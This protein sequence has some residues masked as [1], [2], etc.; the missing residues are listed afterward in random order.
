MN[1]FDHRS[2]SLT[3]AHRGSR[4][5][6]VAL[7][8][9]FILA[10]PM[11]SPAAAVT[12]A[13]I[14]VTVTGAATNP[15]V[16]DTFSFQVGVQ[17]NGPDAAPDVSTRTYFSA[18]WLDFVSFSSADPAATCAI[19]N[20][21]LQCAFGGLEAGATSSVTIQATRLQAASSY[22]STYSVYTQT[23][24]DPYGGN[25][26]DYF[27]LA[28]DRDQ[29]S[30]LSVA[31]TGS[32]QPTVGSN[33]TFDTTVSNLGPKAA[34]N[35]ALT[36]YL[37]GVQ[38][39]FVSVTSANCTYSSGDGEVDCFFPSIPA[40]DTRTVTVTMQRLTGD[41]ISHNASVHLE[42]N[43]DPDSSNNYEYYDI[44]GSAS[45]GS[46]FGVTLTGPSQTPDVG[47]TSNVVA[48]ATNL[49]PLADIGHFSIDV[50]VGLNALS[51]T[52]TNATCAV[53]NWGV[54]CVSN[55]LA[56]SEKA[57]VTVA[58]KRESGERLR[59]GAYVWADENPDYSQDNDDAILEL[60]PSSTRITITKSGDGGG[61]VTSSPA[62]IDCGDKCASN[63]ASD[64]TVSLTVAPNSSS[65]FAGWSG[66]CGG[67]SP[68]CTVTMK[69][70]Q[71]VAA[72]FTYQFNT[73]M[74]DK[75]GQGRG[76][77]RSTPPGIACGTSCEWNFLRGVSITLKADAR[78]GSKFVRWGGACAG[79]SS[80]AP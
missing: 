57:S 4:V 5:F 48:T 59:L 25:D 62:G 18:F 46:D 23:S 17:N 47:T 13:D 3:G 32:S 11:A 36:V 16:G 64:S 21:Y 69:G 35:A 7:V 42:P 53:E 56:A 26:G 70:A 54:S 73:L 22:M 31:M 34:S 33:Y 2:A 55:S 58:V 30:D 1:Q 72:Q 71:T 20:D 49:G 24:S 79:E 15:H 43:L 9:V 80:S 60:G 27:T 8:S 6:L 52:A 68:T 63:F 38:A 74:V 41:W 78:A 75:I 29:G 39:E 19:S 76:L 12:Y 14:A 28:V 67:L 50:P 77:V 10:L 66:A 51:Q 61:N 37:P 40:G 44:E 45:A 65:A